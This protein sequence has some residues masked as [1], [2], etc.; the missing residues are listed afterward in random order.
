VCG[1]ICHKA[2]DSICIWNKRVIQQL[3]DEGKDFSY[4]FSI[5]WTNTEI[6]K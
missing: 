2:I 1:P 6:K 5:I 3:L 4:I